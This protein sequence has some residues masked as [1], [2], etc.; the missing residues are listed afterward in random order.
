MSRA[1]VF[2]KMNFFQKRG[3]P[4]KSGANNGVITIEQFNDRSDEK[5]ET[6]KQTLRRYNGEINYESYIH[7]IYPYLTDEHKAKARKMV[8]F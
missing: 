8:R 5:M 3:I 7:G 6:L 4:V 2:K 1:Y